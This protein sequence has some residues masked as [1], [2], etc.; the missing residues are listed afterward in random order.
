MEFRRVM[1][2]KG[3]LYALDV[4]GVGGFG[5]CVSRDAL[6]DWEAL[7]RTMVPSMDGT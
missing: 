2:A 5:W 3:E 4:G 7:C 1:W 6:G